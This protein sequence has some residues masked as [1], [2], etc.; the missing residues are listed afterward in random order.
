MLSQLEW[1]ERYVQ[2]ARWTSSVRRFLLQQVLTSSKQDVL[3]V[4]CGSGAILGELGK[5]FQA[6]FGIDH[7]F[8]ILRFA[9][10]QHQDDQYGCAD[11]L[12]L[13]FSS[14]A[15]SLTCCHFYLLWVFNPLRAVREMA[16]VTRPGGY[17]L[18]LAEPDYGGRIDYPE[19]L[20]MLGRLQS[21]ALLRQGADPYVGR[22]I[23]AFFQ[24]A[25]LQ[26]I[27]SGVLGGEWG[28]APEPGFIEKEWKILESDLGSAENQ[29]NITNFKA[30]DSAAWQHG[31]RILYVPTFYAT[32]QV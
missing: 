2:Q 22:K 30:L 1:H 25:G 19:E 31:E 29:E 24:Q 23:K 6:V 17:V 32:G 3:E 18:A 12:N 20:A 16:R 14:G 8:K 28:E 27:R 4:G 11:G 9:K 13:P 21:E 26:K 10:G 7:D 15:F 5:Q